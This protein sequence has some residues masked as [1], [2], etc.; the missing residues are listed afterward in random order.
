MSGIYGSAQAAGALGRPPQG[1]LYYQHLFCKTHFI[2]PW[3]QGGPPSMSS[4]P[5]VAAAGPA[6]S[7]PQGPT[8]D[9]FN[10]GGGRYRTCR[11][12]P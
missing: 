5:M 9:V 7:T 10:F 6:D 8:I 11:Q 12:H 1:S 4:T 2:P 3:T